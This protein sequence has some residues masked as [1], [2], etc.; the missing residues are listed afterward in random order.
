[1]P[2]TKAPSRET[3]NKTGKRKSKTSSHYKSM[4]NCMRDKD[5]KKG[6]IDSRIFPA[7]HCITEPVHLERE[8]KRKKKQKTC[9]KAS[10]FTTRKRSKM[11][12]VS[13]KGIRLVIHPYSKKKWERTRV[14]NEKWKNK[15]MSNKRIKRWTQ[16]PSISA[17]EMMIM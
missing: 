14:G 13:R 16:C 17:Q 10:F 4:S 8:R 2:R 9:F 15:S 7:V 1:M 12:V 11:D 5:L 6:D 3:A